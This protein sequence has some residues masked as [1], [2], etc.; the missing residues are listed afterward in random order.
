MNLAKV[1]VV[2]SLFA[3]YLEAD[4]RR[5][6]RKM[7]GFASW[8]IFG[9][10]FEIWIFSR[11]SL[12]VQ[13]SKFRIFMRFPAIFRGP[14]NSQNTDFSAVSWDFE[15]RAHPKILRGFPAM[16]RPQNLNLPAVSRDF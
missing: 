12:D 4:V 14:K 15:G 5:K 1:D 6:E 3:T 7:G 2:V 8:E 10:G 9:T 16:N 11:F 13:V